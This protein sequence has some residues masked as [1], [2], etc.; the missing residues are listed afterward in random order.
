MDNDHLNS[1]SLQVHVVDDEDLENDFLIISDDVED[2]TSL[3]F[4]DHEMNETEAINSRGL[5]FC[6]DHPSTPLPEDDSD[7]ECSSS[8]CL[9]EVTPDTKKGVVRMDIDD[10]QLPGLDELRSH[11]QLSCRKLAGTIWHSEMTRQWLASHFRAG[12]L[13]E[14]SKVFGGKA[15]AFLTGSRS[16]LTAE[17]DCSRRGVWAMIHSPV[18]M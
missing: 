7:E 15:S 2:D 4:M 13:G 18:K 10:V 6:L 9:Y 8:Q 12:S 1:L 3:G 17:L 11:Y 5:D 14:P 16:T